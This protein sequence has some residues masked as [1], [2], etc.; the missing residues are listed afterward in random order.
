MKN[1]VARAIQ[2]SVMENDQLES[3]HRL[4]LNKGYLIPNWNIQYLFQLPTVKEKYFILEDDNEAHFK[5][6]ARIE[7]ELK[8]KGFLGT[9]IFY[10]LDIDWIHSFDWNV[11]NGKNQLLWEYQGSHG[12]KGILSRLKK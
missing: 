9:G 8:E 3:V 2:V 11:Y 12:E 10:E 5:Y 7:K 4:E 6:G 1:Y